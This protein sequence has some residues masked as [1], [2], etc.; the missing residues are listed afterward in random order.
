L[1][2][3]AAERLFKGVN[4]LFTS[5]SELP[6]DAAFPAW[7]GYLDAA[8][9]WAWNSEWWQFLMRGEWRYFRANWLAGSTYNKGDEVYDA[10]T[11]Q[12][13]Q[14]LRNSVTGSGNSPTDSAGDER[15][16]YWALCRTS[17]AGANWLTGT[18][19]AV[20][21]I[22]FY[23]V[24]NTFYQCHTAHTSSGTLVPTATGGDER[25]GALTPFARYVDFLQTGQ[26]QIGDVLV[27]RTGDPRVTTTY[28]DLNGQTLRD[29]YYI[30]DAVT[31]AFLDFRLRRPRLTGTFFDDATVYA[32]GVQV[33]YFSDTAEGNFYTCVTTTTAGETP[34]SAAAKWAVVELP[35]QFQTAL[36]WFAYSRVLVA[37][38]RKPEANDAQAQADF[39]LS[40]ETDRSY[41]QSG[42]TPAVA[43]RCYP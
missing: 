41:R 29:R 25:W 1:N 16:A 40:L 37:D 34:E 35:E 30:R 4:E 23:P 33:Y 15:S 14:C 17:Y 43:M 24:D 28:V 8:L 32:A 21:D 13:F 19:Y 27:A 6:D 22:R 18:V 36:V 2:T 12:Y 42:E 26:T 9:A 38:D 3:I 10:A 11:Q 31:R 7:R 20:G 5:E 39:A